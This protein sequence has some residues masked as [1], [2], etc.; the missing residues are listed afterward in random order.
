MKSKKNK[1]IRMSKYSNAELMTMDAL[2]VYKLVLNKEVTRFPPGFWECP[3]AKENSIICAK[4]LIEDIL[5]WDL[6]DVKSKIRMSVFIKYKLAGMMQTLYK[7]SPYEILSIIYKDQFMPWELHEAPTKIWHE[8][9]NRIKA[10]DWLINTKLKWTREDIINNYNSQ[11]LVDNDLGGLLSEGGQG[12]P[13]KLLDEFMEGEFKPWEFKQGIS[14]VGYWDKKENRVYAIRDLIENVLGWDDEQ[15]KKYLNQDTF[16]NNNLGG[17]IAS[18]YYNGSPY[19]ALIEAY[20]NKNYLPWELSCAPTGL[21]DDKQNRINAVKWLFEIRLKWSIEDIKANISQ[22]VF[23]DNGL[24]S[25]L[26]KRKGGLYSVVSEA[27]PEIHEWELPFVNASF[28]EC[29]ENRIKAM[30]WLFKTKLNWSIEDIKANVSQDTFKTYGLAGLL[31][32]YNGSPYRAIVDYLPDENIKAWELSV[33]P[34]GF[35]K[36]DD[37]C[38]DAMNWMIE[39]FNINLGNLNKITKSFLLEIGIHGVVVN[40]YN[41]SITNFKDDV[42]K[43]LKGYNI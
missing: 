38:I 32:Y 8:K 34:N 3:E 27:Y 25:L 2:D 5:K 41:K 42:Y 4:Y 19:K 35:W 1:N 24:I 23:K 37:N 31:N 21:W 17:L 12:S 7:N 28:W 13:F 6:E 10:M 22:K 30:D 20:P 36:N 39:K 15:I 11:V 43:I 33:T 29:R 9:E 26:C 14:S 16:N 18:K 40:K